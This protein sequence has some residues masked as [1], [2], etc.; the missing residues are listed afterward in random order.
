MSDSV[1]TAAVAAPAPGTSTQPAPTHTGQSGTVVRSTVLRRLFKNPL[2]IVAMA[3]LLVISLLA[4]LAPV[5]APFEENYSNIAKTLAAP[6]SVNILGTDSAGRDVWSRLLFGAQLTLLSALLCAGVAIAIGLPAGLI[7]GYY[8][9]K[10]EAVSNW[11]VS[12][13]MSLPG[14]IVLLTIRAAFGPSVWISMIAFGIL[15]SPSYFRLTR[16]AV[17]SVRNELYVDAA[18]VSG[19]SDWSIIARHIFSVVRAPIIIQTAAIAGVAIAIQSGLEF[20]GLGDPSKAT[21]GVMLSEGFKNVYLTPTLLFWPALAM[22]LTIGGL[23]L[24][25]NA[26]RDALEDGE[27]IKHRKKKATLEGSTAA[28]AAARPSRKSVAAV[29]A[30]TEH[31]LVK[32]T[33]LGV[34]YPQADGSIKK[35]VDDVSFHVDRGEIL[36]IVGESGS[37]KS[38]TAFSILGLLPDNARIV[39]GSIQF[40]GNYT[41]APGEELVSQARLSKLRGRRISYIPQEPM[42]NLDPAFTIGYQLVTPMVRVLGIA[43]EEARKRALK[44][45]TDVGIT[46]PERTFNA[47]PHEVSGGMAQRVLIAG[48]IS[49]EPDLVIADEPTTALDVTVQADV[50]DL[51]RELQQRLNIGVILV[52]HNFGVVADL[53]DRVAVMQNG[54]LVEEGSVRDILRNPKEP[55]TR[56]LLASMLEGKT[57]M[58]MLVSRQKEPVA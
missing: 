2:G 19:L 45:L 18:R 38:Q 50:L 1:E 9:G 25:G 11:V 49:C 58:S 43:K 31:H 3:I 22:A 47:Y 12:I 56:T 23:V 44:L 48:A 57:P 35:V 6:D 52:T 34:G 55:Y 7:A 51:L 15:I 39:A 46:N 53:C 4:V 33:N 28:P 16:T 10:F 21:W 8:A 41:V 29:D 42:S 24:L 26:I 17:Q 20:L 40:D 14:L 13:L 27:K 37:G 32:V 54:R 36:G 30:G 5:L